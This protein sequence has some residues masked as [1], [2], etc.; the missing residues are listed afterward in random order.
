[1]LPLRRN[2]TQLTPQ[3]LVIEDPM[4]SNGSAVC[5]RTR[6][7]RDL[8]LAQERSH[9]L[10]KRPFTIGPKAPPCVFA[11]A[12]LN[13]DSLTV[14]PGHLALSSSTAAG[15]AYLEVQ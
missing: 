14:S 3:A 13:D 12:I 2:C 5:V 1:M 7:W 9:E 11:R 8:T 15:R 10:D 4:P 6:G